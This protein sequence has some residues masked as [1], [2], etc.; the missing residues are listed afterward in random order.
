MASDNGGHRR[1]IS[2]QEVIR[3]MP[4][5]TNGHALG[6]LAADSNRTWSGRLDTIPRAE[7]LRCLSLQRASG[8]FRPAKEYSLED[9]AA[10]GTFL[11]GLHGRPYLCHRVRG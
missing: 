2:E 10:A 4:M 8:A 5:Y 3:R 1:P 7:R 9:G 6:W 11:A